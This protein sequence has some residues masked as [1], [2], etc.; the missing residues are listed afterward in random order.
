MTFV[1]A[2]RQL[3]FASVGPSRAWVPSKCVFIFSVC[4]SLEEGS[5]S[6][7]LCLW[8]LWT[9]SGLLLVLQG[10]GTSLEGA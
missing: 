10:R 6:P 3:S 4:Q 9:K 1:L 8:T 7:E 5:R 2:G